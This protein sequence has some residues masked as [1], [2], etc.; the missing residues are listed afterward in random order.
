M[1]NPSRFFMATF[2]QVGDQ[3]SRGNIADAGHR[4]QEIVGAAPDGGAAHGVVDFII[5]FGE[6]GVQGLQGGAD[7][8]LD[9]RGARL[10]QAV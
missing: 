7:S 10:P 5:E 4:C 1:E 9:A 3:G 6:L 2:G 8:A